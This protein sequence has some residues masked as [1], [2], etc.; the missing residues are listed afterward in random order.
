MLFP[1]FFPLTLEKYGNNTENCNF[2]ENGQ[3]FT[4]TQM[5]V[6]AYEYYLG[7]APW[8]GTWMEFCMAFY[9]SGPMTHAPVS[10][11]EN[12]SPAYNKSHTYREEKNGTGKMMRLFCQTMG[13]HVGVGIVCVYSTVHS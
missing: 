10:R 9:N 3:G 12:R 8:H 5:Q 4:P 6:K 1:H 2:G 7:H 11:E 13:A